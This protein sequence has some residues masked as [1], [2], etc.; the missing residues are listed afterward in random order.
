[1]TNAGPMVLVG[2]SDAYV[3]CRMFQQARRDE[4][5]R[6]AARA[7]GNIGS[8]MEVPELPRQAIHCTTSGNT[9][10]CY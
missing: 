8:N 10:T 1:M 4:A 3:Q 7:I 5:A 6:N 2:G 9:T